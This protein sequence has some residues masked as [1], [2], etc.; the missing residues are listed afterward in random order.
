MLFV[1][2]SLPS[3]SPNTAYNASSPL[4]APRVSLRS[5]TFALA[6]LGQTSYTLGTLYA[7]AVLMIKGDSK[8]ESYFN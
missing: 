5:T 4:W 7:T 1:Y 2:Y 8:Y 6:M 3:P